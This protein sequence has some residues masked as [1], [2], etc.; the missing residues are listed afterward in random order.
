MSLHLLHC[1]DLLSCRQ[2]DPIQIIIRTFSK[3]LIQNPEKTLKDL[4]YFIDLQEGDMKTLIS[5]SFLEASIN[6]QK[7]FRSEPDATFVQLSTETKIAQLDTIYVSYKPTLQADIN[8]PPF[9]YHESMPINK[10]YQRNVKTSTSR[11]Q[12]TEHIWNQT[13][14]K[15]IVYFFL[16]VMC[17]LYINGF[18]LLFYIYEYVIKNIS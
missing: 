14:K 7:L 13:C 10:N 5:R 11:F 3:R 1:V 12:Q 4:S 16:K 17:F 18:V 15:S 2:I 9:M 8:V 6:I